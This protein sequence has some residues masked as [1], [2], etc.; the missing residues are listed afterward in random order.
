MFEYIIGFL[1]TIGAVI[2][3][4]FVTIFVIVTGAVMVIVSFL[5]AISPILAIAF[6]VFCIYLLVRD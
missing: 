6:I 5:Y 2:I 1:T 4:I 3:T